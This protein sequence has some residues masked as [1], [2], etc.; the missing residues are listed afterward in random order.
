[1]KIEFTK[2]EYGLLRVAL[3]L[4]QQSELDFINCHMNQFTKKPITGSKG[5]IARSRRLVRSF[6]K[7]AMKV[8]NA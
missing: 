6:Q 8:Q 2:R 5:I 7:L 1:M 3:Y 4:A